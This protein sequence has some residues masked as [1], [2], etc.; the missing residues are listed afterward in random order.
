MSNIFLWALSVLGSLIM[1]YANF[2][3]S[4]SEEIVGVRMNPFY[5]WLLAESILT[6][7]GMT[8]F[9]FVA[10]KLDGD[11][12]KTAVIFLVTKMV[13]D[14]CLYSIYYSFRPKYA[15]TLLFMLCALVAMKWPDPTED[16]QRQERKEK[17]MARKKK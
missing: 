3:R 16:K 15:I 6:W 4:N 8:N 1:C 10:S 17:I 13:I 12:F 9:E 11:K 5:W 2:F 7:I 14:I